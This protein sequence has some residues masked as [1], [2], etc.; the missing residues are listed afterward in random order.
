MREKLFILKEQTLIDI[1]NAIRT[2]TGTN[3]LIKIQNLDY[4]I[5][6]IQGGGVNDDVATKLME[7][8]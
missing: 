4:A 2:K 1:A 5:A 3:E 7:E 8:Y 6:V